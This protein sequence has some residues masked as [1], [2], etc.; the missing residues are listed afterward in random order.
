MADVLE[1][2]PGLITE[3]TKAAQEHYKAIKKWSRSIDA[4]SSDEE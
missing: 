2:L 3:A 1:S 4:K